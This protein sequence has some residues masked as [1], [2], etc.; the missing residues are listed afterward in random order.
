MQLNIAL[1]ILAR[2]NHRMTRPRL[3]ILQAALKFKGPFSANDLHS[4][5]PKGM[6]LVTIYRNLSAFES[7]GLIC[8]ADFSDE[9]VRYLVSAPGHD[10]H[11]H[12]LVCRSCQK[13]EAIDHCLVKA[14]EKIF[15]QMG[16][17]QLKHRLEFSGLC[18]ACS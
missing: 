5:M 6:D 3:K 14:Q 16:Y 15:K 4:K 1:E 9:M 7:L 13:I 12:H 11:H 17:T 8:R 18:K 2:A 10:H